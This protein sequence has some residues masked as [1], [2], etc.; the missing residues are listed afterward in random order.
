M[1]THTP[2]HHHCSSGSRPLRVKLTEGIIDCCH[3]GW[4]RPSLAISLL[5]SQPLSAPEPLSFVTKGTEVPSWVN[6][7]AMSLF[8]LSVFS[9]SPLCPQ[10]SFHLSFLCSY[11]NL[12]LL[13]CSC[14]YLFLSPCNFLSFPTFFLLSSTWPLS[15]GVFVLE[16]APVTSVSLVSLWVSHSLHLSFCMS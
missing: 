11:L 12:L 14:L 9:S 8:I 16:S 13:V 6:R 2:Q 3:L 7:P 15:G 4:H 1:Q 10:A 5:S